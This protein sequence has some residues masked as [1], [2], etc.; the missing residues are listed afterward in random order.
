M[1]LAVCIC[2]CNC[3]CM[4]NVCVSLTRMPVPVSWLNFLFSLS[5][6]MCLS[7]HRN[8][9]TTATT[10]IHQ[11]AAKLQA[12]DLDFFVYFYFSFAYFTLS[13]RFQQCANVRCENLEIV[14]GVFMC[15]AYRV[16][17]HNSM[18]CFLELFKFFKILLYFKL[19]TYLFLSIDTFEYI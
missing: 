1:Y 5:F 18:K 3:R 8:A 17:V 2:I 7:C 16:I 12:S 10:T 9:I 6:V 15:H 4:Y 14:Y 11:S 19:L 13:T